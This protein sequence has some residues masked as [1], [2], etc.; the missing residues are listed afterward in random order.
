MHCDGKMTY[1]GL[2]GSAV[3]HGHGK[4]TQLHIKQSRF[5]LW[6]ATLC[7]VLAWARHV[8]YSQS[9]SLYLVGI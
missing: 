5:E 4:C 2:T 9:A 7:F 8:Y 3:G 6:L 1:L